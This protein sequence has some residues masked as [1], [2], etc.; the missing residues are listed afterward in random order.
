MITHLIGW[1]KCIKFGNPVS[2]N[3]IMVFTKDV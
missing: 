1:C 3:L 2:N